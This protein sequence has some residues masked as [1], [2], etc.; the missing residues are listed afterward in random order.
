MA[1]VSS[2]KRECD[3]CGNVVDVNST[4]C[5]K[6]KKGKCYTHLCPGC[7][8]HYLKDVRVTKV[9]Q[10][11]YASIRSSIHFMFRY[12]GQAG[13]VSVSKL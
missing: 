6:Q 13:E 7:V 3:R 12:D 9:N 1:V 11:I 10:T 5:I 4:T 2:F 8:R